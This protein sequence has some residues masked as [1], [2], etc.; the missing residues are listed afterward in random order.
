MFFKLSFSVVLVLLFILIRNSIA[1]DDS[2]DIQDN[3]LQENQIE[4][5]Q[6]RLNHLMSKLLR[7]PKINEKLYV[8]EAS[9]ENINYR[10]RGFFSDLYRQS[11]RAF[12]IKTYFDALVQNDGSILLVPKDVNKNHYF[13]G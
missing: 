9:D 8:R 1:R 5:M 13:I 6:S 12:H 10:K 11:K 3:E 7:K 2:H 4:Q